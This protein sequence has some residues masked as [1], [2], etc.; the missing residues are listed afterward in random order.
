MLRGAPGPAKRRP[1]SI[2]GRPLIDVNGLQIS[3]WAPPGAAKD[4]FGPGGPPG[5]LQE[6]SGR[7]LGAGSS[8]K[9][10]PGGHREPFWL[11]F[12]PSRGSFSQV[13]FDF[14]LLETWPGGM[15]EAIK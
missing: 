15:R 11:K 12:G 8:P 3:T 2:P 1:K 7:A 9:S 4:F 5:R 14:L 6:A 10:R 13:F